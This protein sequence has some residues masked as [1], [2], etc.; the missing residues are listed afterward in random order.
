M[1]KINVLFPHL[2]ALFFMLLYFGFAMIWVMIAALITF[3]IFNRKGDRFA[4]VWNMSS[5][6]WEKLIFSVMSVIAGLFIIFFFVPWLFSSSLKGKPDEDWLTKAKETNTAII[7]GFGYGRDENGEM[8]PEAS[9]RFLYELSKKQTNAKFLIVQEG[10]YVATL[11]DSISIRSHS[12]KLVSMHPLNLKEDINTFEAAK[13][14]IMQM[15]KLG[16]T[17]A[18]VYAQ[19]LQQKRALAD[20]KRIAASNSAWKNFTFISPFIPNTPFPSHSAQWRTRY[21]VVYRAIELYYSRV[22]DVWCY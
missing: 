4:Y 19:N 14:A 12:I 18:V 6:T 11:E 7:F 17:Q 22:R 20:L 13:Y 1:D 9:N 3:K 21:K 15:E 16:Q 2:T 8:T 5:Q 10:V